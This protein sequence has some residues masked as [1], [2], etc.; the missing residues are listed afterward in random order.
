M[1]DLERSEVRHFKEE[2][3]GHRQHRR[4]DSD[5]D[6]EVGPLPMAQPA[7]YGQEKKVCGVINLCYWAVFVC[8]C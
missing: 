3:Q 4:E 2:V 5:D 7:E 1:D 8:H 6:D